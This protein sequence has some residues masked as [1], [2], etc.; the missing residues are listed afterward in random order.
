MM[1]ALL[2]GMEYGNWFRTGPAKDLTTRQASIFFTAY[3]FFQVW[4]QINARSLT[5]EMSGFNG[6]LG[7]RTFL[8]I[9]GTIAVVQA[10]IISIPFLAAVFNVEPLGPWDWLFIL[11]GTASVLVFAEVLRRVRLA[12]T[13]TSL[14]S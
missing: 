9:A 10:L 6:L 5:P 11:V 2:C 7:N 4:N 3:V 1:M 13:K 8:G 12:L 14:T